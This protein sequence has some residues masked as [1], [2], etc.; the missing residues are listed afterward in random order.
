VVVTRTLL[1]DLVSFFPWVVRYPSLFGLPKGA[2]TVPTYRRSANL[3][4]GRKSAVALAG[5][6][7]L[8]LG[9]DEIEE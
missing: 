8:D 4:T 9:D 2:I 5:A 6:G 7:D 3:A 1:S